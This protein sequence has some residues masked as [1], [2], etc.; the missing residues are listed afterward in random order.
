M[1]NAKT[2]SQQSHWSVASILLDW[3]AI[4]L[5]MF[6]GYSNALSLNS[7]MATDRV[8]QLHHL[9]GLLVIYHSYNARRL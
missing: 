7:P 5:H 1:S 4:S 3:I 6:T 9:S 2:N 8:A